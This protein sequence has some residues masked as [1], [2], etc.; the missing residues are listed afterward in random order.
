M[1]DADRARQ[2]TEPDIS[3]LERRQRTDLPHAGAGP[4][5]QPRHGE[6]PRRFRK[7]AIAAG[8]RAGMIGQVIVDGTKAGGVAEVEPVQGYRCRLARENAQAVAAGVARDIHQ[9]IDA[10]V[11]DL[12]RQRVVRHAGGRKPAVEVG[13]VTLGGGVRCQYQVRIGHHFKPR[14]VMVGQQGLQEMPR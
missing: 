4:V 3:A 11:P 5:G 10:I 9:H 2:R 8:R 7:Q 6:A 14:V 13:T 1:V 12:L